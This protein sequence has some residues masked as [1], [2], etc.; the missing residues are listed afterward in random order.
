[1]RELSGE[2]PVADAAG[3]GALGEAALRA[4][5]FPLAYAVSAAG[6]KHPRERWAEFLFLR[7]RSLPE[8]AEERQ[9]PCAA[10]ASELAR[11]QRNPDLLRRIGEWREAEMAGLEGNATDVAMNT[12]QIDDLIRRER[13][14]MGY[15]AMPDGMRDFDRECDCPACRASREGLPPGLGRMMDEIGPDVLM[16]ALEEIIAGGLPKRK[17]GRRRRTFLDDFP[18]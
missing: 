8:W 17:N 7:A 10:A 5:D 16:Q 9:G 6:L 2:E 18:F 12:Q 15:P 11:R 3:L 4:H 1:M 14:Q 13:E